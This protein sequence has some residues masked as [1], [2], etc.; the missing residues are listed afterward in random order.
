MNEKNNETKIITIN[1]KAFHNFFVLQSIETGISLKGTEVK[2]IKDGNINLKDGFAL[3]RKGE[4]F[5]KNVHVS[6]YSYGNR[7]N[8]EPLRERKLLLHKRE[9]EKI[10]HKVK[11]KGLTLVPLKV[12]IKNGKVKIEI[13]LCKGKRL[14]NKK[15]DIKKKDEIRELKRNFKSSNLSGKLK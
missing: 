3:I 6:A 2:S 8:H 15:E 5:L 10:V 14:Y 13:G 12:Y 4:A 7:I 11:I 1:K 9:I